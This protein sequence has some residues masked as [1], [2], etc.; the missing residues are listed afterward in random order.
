METELLTYFY[1]IKKK[2]LVKLIFAKA[3]RMVEGEGWAMEATN[4]WE[5]EILAE[6]FSWKKTGMGDSLCEVKYKIG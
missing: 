5:W 2:D 4:V 3:F 1:W 6:L